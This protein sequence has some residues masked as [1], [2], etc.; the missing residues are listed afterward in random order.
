MVVEETS[1]QQRV[2]GAPVNKQLGHESRRTKRR[3]R[4]GWRGIRRRALAP[5]VSESLR[6]SGAWEKFR[7]N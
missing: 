4:R 2:I 6:R 1:D 3:R 7:A 5:P